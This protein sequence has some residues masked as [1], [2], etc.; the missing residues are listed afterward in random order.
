MFLRRTL[1]HGVNLYEMQTWG[2]ML[3]KDQTLWL[4]ED[5]ESRINTEGK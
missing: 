2:T 1:L 4:Y 3:S 5:E